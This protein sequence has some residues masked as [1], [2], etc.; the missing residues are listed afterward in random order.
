[1]T[2]VG[3]IVARRGIP[4]REDAPSSPKM[5]PGAAENGQGRASGLLDRSTPSTPQNGARSAPHRQTRSDA[6]RL[7][8]AQ[9]RARDEGGPGRGRPRIMTTADEQPG[10][11]D[12]REAERAHEPRV[13]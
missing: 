3:Q 6:G 11:G 7:Q 10:D 9:G 13:R 12:R 8:G 4:T 5:A 1:M 2:A